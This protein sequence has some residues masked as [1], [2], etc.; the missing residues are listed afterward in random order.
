MRRS[1]WSL[2]A[3]G[4]EGATRRVRLTLAAMR[5]S[6]RRHKKRPTP[7][8]AGRCCCLNAPFASTGGAVQSLGAPPPAVV[9]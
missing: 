5:S 3:V 2:E 7:G 4:E 1:I 9:L 6:N 8:E